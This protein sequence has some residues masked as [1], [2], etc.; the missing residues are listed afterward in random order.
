ML[1]RSQYSRLQS[2]K[3]EGCFQQL[4][5]RFFL[6]IMTSPGSS[7]LVSSPQF[8]RFFSPTSLLLPP[9]I[10]ILMKL[11]LV[12]KLSHANCRPFTSTEKFGQYQKMP[13]VL[14]VCQ[15]LILNSSQIEFSYSKVDFHSVW[16]SLKKSLYF[17]TL[18]IA[19]EASYI[20]FKIVSVPI[21]LMQLLFYP[22][23]LCRQITESHFYPFLLGRQISESYFY[24]FLLGR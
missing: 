15:K 23:L 2:K 16:K 7:W 11:L 4:L 24:P 20:F 9:E 19:S 13:T 1:L 17:S 5:L 6:L 18:R 22:F 3:K 14:S 10:S 8:F 21:T 12:L